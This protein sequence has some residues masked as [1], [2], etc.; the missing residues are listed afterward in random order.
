VLQQHGCML[1][2]DVKCA[3]FLCRLQQLIS[4]LARRPAW[5][6]L[7]LFDPSLA[8]P[9]CSLPAQTSLKF[10]S[11]RERQTC[12]VSNSQLSSWMI[13]SYECDVVLTFHARCCC[14]RMCLGA[15]VSL[16]RWLVV[17]LINDAPESTIPY[18]SRHPSPQSYQLYGVTLRQTT[19][20]CL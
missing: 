4:F 8:P 20:F 6:L 13:I 16:Q 7:R 11:C 9:S 18:A 15:S 14:H 3:R 5:P 17:K 1:Y 12:Q 10:H 2:Y 19:E